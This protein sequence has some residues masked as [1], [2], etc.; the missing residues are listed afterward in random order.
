MIDVAYLVF[1]SLNLVTWIA[2]LIS[3][4]VPIVLSLIYM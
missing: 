4:K 1:S 3:F 2:L